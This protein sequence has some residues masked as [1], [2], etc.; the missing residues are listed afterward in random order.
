MKYFITGGCGFIGGHLI[1]RLLKSASNQVLN[2]DKLTYAANLLKSSQW[3]ADSRYRFVQ[4]DICDN[5]LLATLLS[6]FKP[7]IVIN[8]AAESHVD[9]SIAHP[10]NFV[11]TNITGVY[12][13][14]EACRC[15]WAPL[16]EVDK[17]RFRFYQISTDE[18]YGD[19]L[20]V[21]LPCTEEAAYK[22]GSPYSASKAAADHLVRAWHRTYKLPTIISTSSNNYGPGQHPEKL[23]P[24]VIARALAGE[25]IPVYGSGKQT[26]DWLHVTDH[27]EAIELL[28]NKS[29][30]GETWNVAGGNHAAN[31]DLVQQIC[32]TLDEMA[33]QPSLKIRRYEALIQFVEDRPGHDYAYNIDSGK[34]KHRLNWQPK[35]EFKEGLRQTVQSYCSGGASSL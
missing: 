9:T 18:V 29:E 8:L 21:P 30:P 6:E 23:I 3:D 34:I 32:N 27:V 2:L 25:M 13:L 11:D 15:Y 22:P 35:I 28:A 24:K 17:N 4:G 33:P 31:I 7:Q 20:A 10:G 12:S 19:T 1:D 26:R 14:L 5:T 16:P